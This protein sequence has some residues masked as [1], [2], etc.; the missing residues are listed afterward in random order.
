MGGNGSRSSGDNLLVDVVSGHH[1][2]S[3]LLAAMWPLW[4]PLPGP[5]G[6]DSHALCEVRQAARL[7]T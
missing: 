4:V 1:R 7:P 5:S 2:A 3:R 6:A